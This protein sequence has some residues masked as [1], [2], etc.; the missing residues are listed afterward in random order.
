[1]TTPRPRV[2]HRGLATRRRASQIES[3]RERG[4]ASALPPLVS[5][6]LVGLATLVASA[7]VALA[8]VMPT[9]TDDPAAAF[10]DAPEVRTESAYRA[11]LFRLAGIL[12]PCQGAAHAI[13]RERCGRQTTRQR[14]RYRRSVIRLLV[15]TLICSTP[16][17]VTPG[18][19]FQSSLIPRLAA[20]RFP[21]G[22]SPGVACR[23]K[24]PRNGVAA[25]VLKAGVEIPATRWSRPASQ[26]SRISRSPA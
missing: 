6:H 14:V 16:S 5:A 17:Y 13:D 3:R 4:A 22:K 1:M 8:G 21:G 18:V 11:W 2:P 25:S 19:I 12:G 7:A 9:W 10:P 24:R 15:P 23:C 20:D 26:R